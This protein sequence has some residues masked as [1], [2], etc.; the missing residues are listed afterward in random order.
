MPRLIRLDHPGPTLAPAPTTSIRFFP[1][2]CGALIALTSSIAF[3]DSRP[4]IESV[5]LD[6]PFSRGD[7]EDVLKGEI[8]VTA[9]KHR[10]DRELAVGL[11]CLVAEGADPMTPFNLVRS[12]LPTKTV[13]QFEVL[14]PANPEQAFGK[15]KLGAHARKEL[16]R[17]LDFEPGVGLNLSAEEADSFRAVRS[18]H[19]KP[20]PADVV[21][22]AIQAALQKRYESY[23][24]KGL[25]GIAPYLRDSGEE[26][27]PG[28]E[29]GRILDQSYALRRIF[30]KFMSMWRAYPEK[31][32]PDAKETYFWVRSTVDDRP[33]IVLAHQVDWQDDGTRLLGERIFY[34]SHFFDAG[35]TVAISMPIR[36][37]RLFALVE[38]VWI[39]GYTRFSSA[40]KALGQKMLKRKLRDQ[41]KRREACIDD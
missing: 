9:V 4:S 29:L 41:V 38:R 11:A 12:M 3:A 19:A 32:L 37:G 33:M 26:A 35:L 8:V 34:A 24:D 2:L 16:G 20:V 31:M 17:Y 1:L 39:D 7:L 23:R 18:A 40:K 14:D 6:S 13:D 10:S 27:L 30:P 28:K 22:A 15:L 21:D 25:S 5:L 36:E